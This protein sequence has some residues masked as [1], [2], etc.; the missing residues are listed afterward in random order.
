MEWP[1]VPSLPPLQEADEA[2]LARLDLERKIESLEEEI[3]FLRKIHEEVRPGLKEGSP[4][5]KLQLRQIARETD[6][7]RDRERYSERE[8]EKHIGGQ[9]ENERKSEERERLRK[10][11][12]SKE[13]P[14]S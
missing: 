8:V 10:T 2:T 4:T 11:E 9:K 5:H 7:Q 3:R 13:H 12:S 6:S 14:N 1:N